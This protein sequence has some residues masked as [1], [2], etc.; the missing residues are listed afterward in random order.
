MKITELE[1]TSTVTKLAKSAKIDVDISYLQ[2]IARMNVN[3]P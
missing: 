2:Q 3:T 1:E